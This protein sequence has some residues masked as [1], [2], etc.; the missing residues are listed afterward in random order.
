M[1]NEP[2]VV[3]HLELSIR[4]QSLG[5]LRPLAFR[6]P[7]ILQIIS[8]F[9]TNFSLHFRGPRSELSPF[10]WRHFL[11]QHW[12]LS[13]LCS[14]SFPSFSEWFSVVCRRISI[15]WLVQKLIIFIGRLSRK[16]S[17][18][19]Y[20][21]ASAFDLSDDGSEFVDIVVRYRDENAGLEVRWCGVPTPARSARRMSTKPLVSTGSG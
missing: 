20:G 10:V 12:P 15:C 16:I 5:W 7:P 6:A 18:F 11:R 19:C 2:P 17:H 4:R 8:R 9:S 1:I 14:S 13:V 21:T 3:S